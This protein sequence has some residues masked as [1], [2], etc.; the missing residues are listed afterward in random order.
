ME[1]G[2]WKLQNFYFLTEKWEW[3]LIH[4]TIWK[5]KLCLF[6]CII[7]FHFW[8]Q[9]NIHR[10]LEGFFF[11]LLQ[12]NLDIKVSLKSFY[13]TS[14]FYMELLLFLFSKIEIFE[15]HLHRCFIFIFKISINYFIYTLSKLFFYYFAFTKMCLSSRTKDTGVLSSISRV[16][17]KCFLSIA[18]C[19]IWT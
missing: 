11:P 9:K 8:N 2:P 15:N 1:Q 14:K 5:I 6:F 7:F 16:T 3:H 12:Y 18:P 10:V 19:V 13:F 4:E 17:V